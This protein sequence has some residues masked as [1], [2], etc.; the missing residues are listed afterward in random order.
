MYYV[1]LRSGRHLLE[2]HTMSSANDSENSTADSVEDSISEQSVS[3]ATSSNFESE[4]SSESEVSSDGDADSDAAESSSESD[5]ESDEDDEPESEADTTDDEQATSD[6]VDPISKDLP[7]MTGP[8]APPNDFTSK[9]KIFVSFVQIAVSLGSGLDMRWPPTVK[10]VINYFSVVNFDFIFSSVT[11]TDCYAVASYYNKFLLV[12]CLPMAG[13]LLIAAVYLLPRYFECMCYRHASLQQRQRSKMKFWKLF[14][15]TLFLLYPSMSSTVL[16][17]YVCEDVNGESLLHADHR[18]QCHT[19]QWAEYTLIGIPLI[20]VYPVGIPAYFLILLYA[21]RRFL[22]ES[23][24]QAQLGFLYT[25]YRLEMWWFEIADCLYKLVMTSLLTFLPTNVQLPFAMCIVC[26]YFMVSIYL[27]PY[28]RPSDDL[29]HSLCLTEI[30]LLVMAG[31]VFAATDAA[32][33]S[34]T[35]DIAASVAIFAICALFV[36]VFLWQFVSLAYKLSSALLRKWQKSRAK[37][38]LQKVHPSAGK[39]NLADDAEFSVSQAPAWQD[40][41]EGEEEEESAPTAAPLQGQTG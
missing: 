35:D 37:A 5:S 23:R 12:V 9:L 17:L 1:V 10:T 20:V 31:Y 32:S 16:Q 24:V 41:D 14:L 15:Y 18:V 26:L 11:S 36:V 13:L 34:S 33:F 21:N 6:I 7:L 39:P 4:S 3:S 40:A 22:R 2:A 25:A 27:N 8:P 30:M 28:I 29:L 38:R 19:S